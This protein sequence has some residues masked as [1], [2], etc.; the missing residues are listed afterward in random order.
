MQV[1]FFANVRKCVDAA[2]KERPFWSCVFG[3]GGQRGRMRCFDENP[4]HIMILIWFVP[5]VVGGLW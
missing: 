2:L 5:F 1:N 4:V 3:G